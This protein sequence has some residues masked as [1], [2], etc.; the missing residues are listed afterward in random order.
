[1]KTFYLVPCEEHDAL[2]GTNTDVK[3]TDIDVATTQ[4]IANPKLDEDELA[5]ELRTILSKHLNRKPTSEPGNNKPSDMKAIVLD[6]L[7]ED[8]Q[9]HVPEPKTQKI[10]RKPAVK[11]RLPKKKTPD[12]N[13][14]FP[15]TSKARSPSPEFFATP[16]GYATPEPDPDGKTGK[17]SKALLAIEET[18]KSLQKNPRPV[19]RAFSQAQDRKQKGGWISKI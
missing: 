2:S 18:R 8:R 19:T 4:V 10:P 13:D 14:E 16:S 17:K 7:K 12:F 9:K 6:A 5:A 15:T 3:K 11:K 1:M